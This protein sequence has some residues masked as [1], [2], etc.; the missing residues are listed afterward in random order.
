MGEEDI[1]AGDIGVEEEESY[2]SALSEAID[3]A[4]W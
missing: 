1:E 3:L 2:E 4:S